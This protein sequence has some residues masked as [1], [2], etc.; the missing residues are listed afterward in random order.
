MWADC[1][2]IFSFF[3]TPIIIFAGTLG[4]FSL[5]L[6]AVLP[7]TALIAVVFMFGVNLSI[8][9]PDVMIDASVAEKVQ[10]YPKFGSDL[11]SLCWGSM[12]F[13]SVI[14]YGTS[15]ILISVGGPQLIFGILIPFSILVFMCGALGWFGEEQ[16]LKT[17]TEIYCKAFQWY[18]EQYNVNKTLFKLAAAMSSAA[19]VLALLV[20]GI[21]D[22]FFR[23]AVVFVI[24][25][26]VPTLFYKVSK[27]EGHADVANCGLLLFLMA[28]VTP[29][30][31][32]TMFYW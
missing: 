15:G 16:T 20:I 2:A 30:V 14:G 25:V 31:A 3:R 22:W 19:L 27:G 28:A 29:D 32:T 24:G 26:G 5:F 18:E 6:L 12:A 10:M 1:F 21:T 4:S 11:Q 23:F 8:A 7:L 17:P 9:S 13:G